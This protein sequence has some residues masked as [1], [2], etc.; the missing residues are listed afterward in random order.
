MLAR[1]LA[2]PF[3]VILMGI[4]ASAM[5]VPALHAYA[6]GDFFTGRVF[7][8]GASVFLVLF[9]LIALATANYAAHRPGRSHLTALLAAFT[10][11][12]LMLAVPFAEALRDTSFLNAYVEM[13][14]SFTTTGATLFP[15]ERLPDSLHLWR[16]QVGWMGGFFVWLTAVAIL[17][18]MNLG[19]F[20]VRASG[21]IGQGAAGEVAAAWASE[22][23]ELL[24]R[25][26]ARLF[27]VYAGLTGALW[28]GLLLAGDRPFVALCHAMSVMATSGISPVGGIEGSN[29]GFAGEAMIFLFFVFALTRVSFSATD[30]DRRGAA[31]LTDSELRLGL[32]II[33]AVPLL[34]FLRHWLDTPEEVRLID[35]IVGLGGGAFTVASFLTTTGFLS[36]G[37]DEAQLWSGLESPGL[38]L[39]GLAVFGGGVATT[40]GGVKLL[41]VYALYRHGLREMEKLSL[42]SSIGGAGQAARRL[43]REGAQ[44]AWVFFMLFALS[45]CA[46]MT[47]LALA[48]LDFEEGLVLTIAALSTTGP[49]TEV[50]L[51]EPI[52]LN[53]LEP[54]AKLVFAAAMVIGRLETLAIIALLNPAFWR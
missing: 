16:A 50:A 51:A 13:V 7:F 23:S 21:E 10:L 44:A 5:L 43:R 33:A 48:G 53:A 36:A 32:L 27:P 28:L 38:I 9:V 29:S 35:G 37:W 49:L 40:A 4:G 8:Y 30:R 1:I 15:P 39:M 25:Y 12:P 42:P 45:I 6:T 26:A 14:S 34:L 54:A 20:E 19:G 17:A 46:V 22:P 2:L 18:P 41:R 31:L 24:R 52:D 47:A 3:I 11:L